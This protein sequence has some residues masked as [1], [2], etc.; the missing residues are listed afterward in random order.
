MEMP[1]ANTDVNEL[2][3]QNADMN[4]RHTNPPSKDV[5]GVDRALINNTFHF[6]ALTASLALLEKGLVRRSNPIRVL[7][8]PISFGVL[9]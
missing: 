8:Y 1:S 6:I 4:I 5:E 2:R 3:C 9:V 7:A